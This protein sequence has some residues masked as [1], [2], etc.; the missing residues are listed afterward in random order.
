MGTVPFGDSP[1]AL[2]LIVVRAVDA[3][4]WDI[5][6]AGAAEA[7]EKEF[8]G[9]TMD[10]FPRI[11]AAVS[12]INVTGSFVNQ[13]NPEMPSVVLASCSKY[14]L[15]LC[16]LNDMVEAEVFEFDRRHD[17]P[18][19]LSCF[20]RA[21]GVIPGRYVSGPAAALEDNGVPSAFPA[22]EGAARDWVNNL[23]FSVIMLANLT[24]V[25]GLIVTGDAAML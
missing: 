4:N 16:K 21:V 2:E 12:C 14:C 23:I 19:S 25:V 20:E 5:V 22:T 7:Y 15:I 11:S 9:V 1:H 13:E 6:P 3:I 18:P 10:L 8:L 17:K 24:T